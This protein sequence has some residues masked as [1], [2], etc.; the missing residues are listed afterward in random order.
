MRKLIGFYFCNRLLEKHLL[1]V[2]GFHIKMT[3]LLEQLQFLEGPKTH[4]D[5]FSHKFCD[6]TPWKTQPLHAKWWMLSLSFMF[7]SRYECFK[8]KNTVNYPLLFLLIT[9]SFVVSIVSNFSNLTFSPVCWQFLA[10]DGTLHRQSWVYTL[11]VKEKLFFWGGKTM[12]WP[13]KPEIFQSKALY[14]INEEERNTVMQLLWVWR[15]ECPPAV[16][17]YE[18]LDKLSFP[19]GPHLNLSTEMKIILFNRLQKGSCILTVIL[20]YIEYIDCFFKHQA[21]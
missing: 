11:P 18:T 6:N 17:C 5:Q 4:L 16:T 10:S 15:K 3:S 21:E 14:R 9:Y 20:L 13:E 2:W 12:C 1:V 19:S 7:C 8:Y